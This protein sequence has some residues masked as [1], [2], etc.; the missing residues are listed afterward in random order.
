MHAF[1][2]CYIAARR[3]ACATSRCIRAALAAALTPLLEKNPTKIASFSLPL[4]FSMTR[5]IVL[6]FA[7][8]LL[9]QIWRAGIVAWP[10][11]TL[12]ISVVLALPILAAIERATPTEV[13][14]LA[15]ALVGRF[16]AGAARTVATVFGS[17]PSKYD[18]H[19]EDT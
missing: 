10:E 3:A 18:D 19:R 15:K 8:A 6:A 14:D 1:T 7:I 2:A 17:E 13:M 16:G 12:A 9:R 5:L 4:V 11:A